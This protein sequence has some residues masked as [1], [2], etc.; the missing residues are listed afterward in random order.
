[1]VSIIL[2]MSLFASISPVASVHS[3][4]G[5]RVKNA[6]IVDFANGNPLYVCRT[7]YPHP[8]NDYQLGRVVIDVGCLFAYGT[9][10]LIERD[11]YEVLHDDENIRLVFM[12]AGDNRDFIFTGRE[13]GKIQLPCALHIQ[14]AWHPGKFIDGDGC[15]VGYGNAAY[16][17]REYHEIRFITYDENEW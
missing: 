13:G 16:S 14:G 9:E 17:S 2:I 4:H 12:K 5:R 7:H 1:M 10:E 8:K 3:S 11:R 15:Y 6:Y